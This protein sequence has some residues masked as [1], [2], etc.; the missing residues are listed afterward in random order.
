MTDGN[1]QSEMLKKEIKIFILFAFPWVI[2]FFLV[3]SNFII[4]Q[5][6]KY[7]KSNFIYQFSDFTR[8]IY[9]FEPVLTLILLDDLR[10]T[11]KS[12]FTICKKREIVLSRT[13]NN[14]DTELTS[15]V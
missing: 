5:F 8:Y 9:V 11:L 13:V 6:P 14:C 1:V 10:L 15:N 12:K 3:L 7:A 4:Q 2:G